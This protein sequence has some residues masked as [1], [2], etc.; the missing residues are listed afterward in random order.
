MSVPGTAGYPF[1]DHP[2]VVSAPVQLIGG[3]EDPFS[4]TERIREAVAPRFANV[5][6]DQVAHVGHWPHVEQPD[7]VAQLLRR[8]LS[9][10]AARNAPANAEHQ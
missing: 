5:R 2:S 10:L 3:G 9:R 7:A 4:S 1:R 6:T 8:F